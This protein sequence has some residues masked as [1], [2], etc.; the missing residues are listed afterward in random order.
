[1]ALN[2]TLVDID[3][4]FYT[5]VQGNYFYQVI[6][7]KNLNFQRTKAPLGSTIYTER[8]QFYCVKALCPFLPLIAPIKL[9]GQIEYISNNKR[10]L[11]TY[12]ESFIPH[13]NYS[14]SSL[15]FFLALIHFLVL[16]RNW[17]SRIYSKEKLD[18]VCLYNFLTCRISVSI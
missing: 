11:Y 1:M 9:D 18:S 5:S 17:V 3:S 10:N 14:S 6:F 13:L 7:G 12:E 4:I 8:H 2:C 15:I 16:W